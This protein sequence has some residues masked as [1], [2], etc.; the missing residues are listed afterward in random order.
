MPTAHY[1]LLCYMHVLCRGILE[2]GYNVATTGEIERYGNKVRMDRAYGCA[3][4][5]VKSGDPPTSGRK[6]GS[7]RGK[8]DQ[9][10]R[11][12]NAVATKLMA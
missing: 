2:T 12:R 7:V 1:S 5:S 4:R 10:L 3:G 8:A 9:A 11:F 6:S